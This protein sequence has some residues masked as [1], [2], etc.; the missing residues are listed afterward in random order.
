MRSKL[1][2]SNLI[3]VNS[4]FASMKECVANSGCKSS[5]ASSQLEIVQS[6]M[7]LFD[8]TNACKNHSLDGL[9]PVLFTAVN[10]LKDRDVKWLHLA[11][12]VQP[13]IFNF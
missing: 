1:I 4:E 6:N 8:V 3:A 5:K 9:N 7:N 11:I 12:Q 13:T 10:P 2:V